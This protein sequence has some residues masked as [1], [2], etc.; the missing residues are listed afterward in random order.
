MLK[1]TLASQEVVLKQKNDAADALIQVLSVE[2]EA[3]AREQAIGKLIINI[4]KD[5]FSCLLQNLMK[6]LKYSITL[7]LFSAA[8]EEARVTIIE[9]DVSQQAAVCAEDLRKA[10]PALIAA[11]EALNTLNKN[12]LTELKSFGT[13]PDAVV[14]VTAAVLVLFSEKGKVPKDRSWK[15]CK[16]MM[17]KV[18]QFLNDLINYD[19]ENIHSDVQKAIQPYIND[20]EFSPEK[21]MSKSIAAAGLCAWVINIMRFFDVYVVVEPK[22]RALNRANAELAEARNKLAELKEKLG[23][24]FQLF[25]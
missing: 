5:I 9:E 2:N 4:V 18:D 13:P 20:P 16:L 22:R 14:N 15:A 23:V 12:N 11:Q 25:L 17:G 7:Y 21:I 24:S 8:E 10:E 19:K 1:V 3:V 6:N